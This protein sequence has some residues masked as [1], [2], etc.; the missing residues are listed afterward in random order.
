MKKN[1]K[2]ISIALVVMVL[3]SCD[4]NVSKVKDVAKQFVEGV[5]A[6]DKVTIYEMYPNT[7]I[8]SNLLLPDTI[9]V[10]GIKVEFD[11]TDSVYV[12]KLNDKQSLICKIDSGEVRIC[13]SYNVLKLDSLSYDLAAKTGYPVKQLSDMTAGSTFSDEG[14]F[15]LFLAEKFP[16]AANGN[17]SQENGR[18][19]WRGGWYPSVQFDFPVTNHG[20]NEVKG[21]DYNMEC[22]FYNRETGERIGTSIEAGEDL[23]PGETKVFVVFK[24]E[25]FN[26]ANNYGIYCNP[27][28][29]FKNA[30]KSSLL[31]RYGSFTGKEYDEFVKQ[32]KEKTEAK[33]SDTNDSTKV[34][35]VE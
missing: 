3:S 28:F 34:A 14:D 5:I 25:L 16:S 10:D 26:I 6:K 7:R 20:E 1:I 19:S 33:E 32:K 18:Y 22:V 27:I 21:E 8:F 29:K 23:A 30:S 15:I 2:L 9:K 24:N 13:D 11:K 12:V 31:I 35:V 17:L 4:E